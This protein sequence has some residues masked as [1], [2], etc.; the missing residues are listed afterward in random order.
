MKLTISCH[1]GEIH[2]EIENTKK[3]LSGGLGKLHQEM[4]EQVLAF[5]R[6]G[7]EQE[8]APDGTAWTPLAKRTVKLRGRAHP[9]LRRSGK[10]YRSVTVQA[11]AE[12]AVVGTNWPYARVHQMG[13]VIERKGG[14]ARIHFKKF[15]SGKRKGQV[16]FSKAKDATYGMKANV[17]PYKIR[18]PARPYLFSPDGSIPAHW[19]SALEQIVKA[20]ME[21]GS[22]A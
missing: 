4:G 2:A 12:K 17:G 6:I 14:V 20:Y 3:R 10:L 1:C 11:S 21:G 5:A 9:I 15:K 8:Q 13:A 22:N 19:R 7:F 18:I 16:R